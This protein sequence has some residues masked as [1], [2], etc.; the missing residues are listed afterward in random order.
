[1]IAWEYR[2]LSAQTNSLEQLTA[3]LNEL[4]LEGW[5][6]IG[7]AS[8]DK[9]IGL[10]ALIAMLRRA[11]EALTAPPVGTP[12]GWVSDPSGRYAIRYWSGTGWTKW[13]CDKPGGNRS[14][15]PPYGRVV[16]ARS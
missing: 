4:G 1:V 3:S 7:F 11:R 6:M 16:D 8:A 10:N 5:E 9:T 15:D 12:E 14:E 13:V 2:S